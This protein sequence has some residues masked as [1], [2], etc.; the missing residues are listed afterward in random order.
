[1][2]FAARHCTRTLI[3]IALLLSVVMPSQCNVDKDRKAAAA[4]LA[5]VIEQLRLRKIYVSDFLDS[6]GAR[7]EKS[8]YFSSVFSTDLAKQAKGF[9]ILNRISMQKLLDAA[10]ISLGDL[11]KP[12]TLS[13]I[14]S[15]TGTDALLSAVITIDK[16][17]ISVD[18]SLRD[19]STGNELHR[20]QYQEH[21]S[22]DFEGSFP[23]AS[24]TSGHI[25]YF[26]GLDG[27][28]FPKCVYCPNPSYTSAARKRKVNGAC[29]ISAQVTER[30]TVDDVLIVRSLDSEL[31]E[32]AL[33]IVRTWKLE[34]AKDSSG[35]LVPVRVPVEVTFQL[36]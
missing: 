31:D 24:D 32:A 6:S 28:S 14:G 11:Q 27:I 22:P 35:T 20:T 33:R 36:Y 8:C 16:A 23:A 1:M 12:E 25:Y 18:L 3:L 19:T 15:V 13:K 9:E 21:Y 30:G 10:S 17:V 7:T 5:R 34:P 26:S 4:H 29:L 2:Y